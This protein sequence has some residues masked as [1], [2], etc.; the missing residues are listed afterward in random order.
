MISD[1]DLDLTNTRT[2]SPKLASMLKR[3]LKTSAKSEKLMKLDEAVFQQLVC[4]S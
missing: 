1:V 3:L 4:V 2:P